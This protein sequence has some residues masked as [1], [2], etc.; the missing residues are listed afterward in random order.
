MQATSNEQNS[1]GRI[2]QGVSH[3]QFKESKGKAAYNLEIVQKSAQ[4]VSH[5]QCKKSKSNILRCVSHMQSKNSRTTILQG[6]TC[7]Q[8]AIFNQQKAGFINVQYT[9]N[10]KAAIEG[11]L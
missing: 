9:C 6:A 5:V 8:P 7:G 1:K 2:L 11:F 10:G 3:I 4:I